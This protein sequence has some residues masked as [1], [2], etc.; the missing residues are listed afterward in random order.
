MS[1]PFRQ[2]QRTLT[3]QERLALQNLTTFALDLREVIDRVPTV[4]PVSIES[5]HRHDDRARC[6][7][8]AKTK[9]EEAV[10]WATKGIT[11]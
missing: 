6:L 5:A 3:E 4:E 10:M 2:Q 8:I 11:A 7:A 9:L 1:D